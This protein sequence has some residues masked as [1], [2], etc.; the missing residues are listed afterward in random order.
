[1]LSLHPYLIG[2]PFRIRYL[3]RA[4]AHIASHDRVWLATGAEVVDW[5]RAST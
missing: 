5:Y 3:E 2:Q 1:V 4:L